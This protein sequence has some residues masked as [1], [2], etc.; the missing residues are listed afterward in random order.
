MRLYFLISFVLTQS[1]VMPSNCFEEI[2]W[3]S[4]LKEQRR[5]YIALITFVI[6]LIDIIFIVFNVFCMYFKRY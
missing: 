6:A 3:R 2:Q 5:H 1:L 4:V